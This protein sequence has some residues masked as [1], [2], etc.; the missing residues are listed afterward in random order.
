MRTSALVVVAALLL[1]GCADDGEPVSTEAGVTTVEPTT[2]STTTTTAASS[3]TTSTSALAPGA[4]TAP[5]SLP[6][7]RLDLFPYEGDELAVVAVAAD[8]TLNLRAGPG[9]EFDVVA[10]LEPTAGVVATGHNRS[11]EG[12]GIWVEVTATGTTGWA[13][14]AYLAHLGATDD[15]TS[16]IV[17]AGDRPRAETMLDLGN[18]VARLRAGP[19]A[20][21][22]PRLQV[23]VVDGPSVGDLGEVTVD[24]VGFADDAVLGERLRV[25]GQPDPGGESFSLRTVEATTLCRRGVSDGL[26]V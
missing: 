26:C 4:T 13:N 20:E 11:I 22:E 14:S 1:A 9:V 6:G 18:E 24:V 25:F 17:S 15:V 2:T 3:T 10:E 23:V 12:G 5:G 21:G 8:D 19:D 16:Q 7:E